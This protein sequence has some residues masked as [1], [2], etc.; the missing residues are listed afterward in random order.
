MTAP[1]TD[2]VVAP[3]SSVVLDARSLLAW[4]N[5][6]ITVVKRHMRHR[7]DDTAWWAER[8]TDASSAQRERETLRQVANLIHVERANTRGRIHGNF[9]S[10]EK[11]RAWLVRKEKQTCARAAAY[12]RVPRDSTL[13]ALRAGQVE[14]PFEEPASIEGMEKRADEVH[15]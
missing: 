5:A 10:L 12:L 14:R 1:A 4:T 11:Q 8:D 9:E 13:I 15:S 3:R 7:H 2:A 6:R